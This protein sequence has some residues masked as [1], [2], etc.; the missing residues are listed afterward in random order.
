MGDSSTGKAQ[1]RV[2]T[3]ELLA[4]L[5]ITLEGRARARRKLDEARK[6]LTRERID[7]MRTQVGLPPRGT[8]PAASRARQTL[9]LR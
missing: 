9:G 2:S 4:G 3:E 1:P 5:D 7:A 8:R 6:R